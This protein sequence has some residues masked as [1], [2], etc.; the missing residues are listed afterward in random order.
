MVGIEVE[1]GR[2]F[3]LRNW[4]NFVGEIAVAAAGILGGEVGSLQSIGLVIFLA[5]YAIG[6]VA[7]S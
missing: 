7:V 4:N 2:H 5:D 6:V 3:S 1:S